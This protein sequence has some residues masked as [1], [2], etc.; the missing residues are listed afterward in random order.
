M[1]WVKLLTRRQNSWGWAIPEGHRS[2]PLPEM[3]KPPDL[4]GQAALRIWCPEEA[5]QRDI[6][7]KRKINS[8]S[9]RRFGNIAEYWEEITRMRA[10]LAELR[11]RAADPN[12][13]VGRK[14]LVD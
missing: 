4:R 7:S 9:L 3:E 1:P 10:L 2:K 6:E 5:R 14:S 12:E 8:N 13:L 11:A